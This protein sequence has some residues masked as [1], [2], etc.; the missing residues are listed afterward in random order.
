MH[1]FYERLDHF[2]IAFSNQMHQ[3][4]NSASVPHI[5]IGTPG[6]K[7]PESLW[8]IADNRTNQSRYTLFVLEVRIS[9]P[10]NKW[11]DVL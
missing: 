9:A 2:Q 10:S 7:R 5:H 8:V 4:R 6:S 11:S 1:H 3:W